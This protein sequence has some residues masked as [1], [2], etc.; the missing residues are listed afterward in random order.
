MALPAFAITNLQTADWRLDAGRTDLT[1]A[2]VTAKMIHDIAHDDA[3]RARG[4]LATLYKHNRAQ[5]RQLCAEYCQQCNA[6]YSVLYPKWER[7]IL[8][9]SAS[10]PTEAE[11]E[12][13]PEQLFCNVCLHPVVFD[14]DFFKCP[15]C[16]FTN[17]QALNTEE[18]D[19]LVASTPTFPVGPAPF[20]TSIE[21]DRTAHRF[22]GRV[23]GHICGEYETYL[24]ANQDITAFAD[25]MSLSIAVGDVIPTADDE[26]IS[27]LVHALAELQET[28]EQA[29]D[30]AAVRAFAR[31]AYHVGKGIEVHAVEDAWLVPS[32]TRPN[33]TH[34]V[35]QRGGAIVCSC[36]AGIN[37]A[38]C[39][40]AAL[41]EGQIKAD[42]ARG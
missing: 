4:I 19:R 10:E 6:E 13:E 18:H 17:D 28:A 37:G 40:H 7:W 3:D 27:R 21:Y 12:P 11:P 15:W 29:E 32:G 1:K 9:G 39:W 2:V 35:Q 26:R 31:A 38:Q 36:E 30:Y 8:T 14:G 33:T 16:G 24:D 25:E 41:I 5:L 20:V 22:V 23:N 34:T 42:Q